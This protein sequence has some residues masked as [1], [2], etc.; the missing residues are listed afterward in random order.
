MRTAALS[1]LLFLS[2]F[3]WINGV[4][5]ECIPDKPLCSCDTEQEAIH[6][7]NMDLTTLPFPESGRLRGFNVLGLTG[8]PI[9]RLPSQEEILKHYPD[10][11][12]TTDVFFFL[13]IVC[14]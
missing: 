8:N 6:C 1:L 4:R 9:R 13:G 2:T 12:V 5:F 3:E 10:L 14:Q 7:H 11:M